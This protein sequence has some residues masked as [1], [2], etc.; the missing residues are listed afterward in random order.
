MKVA[1]VLSDKNRHW[2]L[3]FLIMDDVTPLLLSFVAE[4]M[5]RSVVRHC[6]VKIR[7]MS[8]GIL[9]GY[10][11]FAPGYYEDMEELYADLVG[12]IAD[13]VRTQAGQSEEVPLPRKTISAHDCLSQLGV[14]VS[15]GLIIPATYP[16]V[17]SAS[18]L[19]LVA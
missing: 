15:S 12:R 16:G 10:V 11:E 13:A 3:A 6:V 2:A 17:K 7:R 14:D 1:N 19:T 18:L 4:L 8:L 9:F 5:C